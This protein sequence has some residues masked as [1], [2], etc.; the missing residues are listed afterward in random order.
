MTHV[1]PGWLGER[2]DVVHGANDRDGVFKWTR[3]VGDTLWRFSVLYLVKAGGIYKARVTAYAVDSHYEPDDRTFKQFNLE[4]FTALALVIADYNLSE[5]EDAMR[6]A[7]AHRDRML[8]HRAWAALKRD[9]E[10]QQHAS[11]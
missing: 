6:Q 9:T 2:Q 10:R 8:K 3:Y 4:D 11:G 1:Y 5:A 7:I